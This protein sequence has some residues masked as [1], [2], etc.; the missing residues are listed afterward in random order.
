MKPILEDIRLLRSDGNNPNRMTNKQKEEL[1]KSLQ[2]FGWTDPILTNQDGVFTDGEQ[3]VSVCIAHGEFYAPVYRM[4]DLSEVQRRRLRLIANE[5]KG[6]HNREL[7]EAEWQRIIELG[8]REEL[9][10]F[11]DS[12]GEKLPEM[13]RDEPEKVSIIPETYEL[14]VECNNEADQQAKFGELQAKGW[15]VRVLNL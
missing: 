10:S 7:E 11:L 6:K 14:I 3:R 4:K 15:K 2:E 1:W 9:E 13:L 8:Q 5:L 12:M